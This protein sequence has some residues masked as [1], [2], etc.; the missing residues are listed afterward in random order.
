VGSGLGTR[1][2]LYVE[3]RTAEAAPTDLVR[4][5]VAFQRPHVAVAAWVVPSL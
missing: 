1:S 4:V 3:A 5:S 2:A